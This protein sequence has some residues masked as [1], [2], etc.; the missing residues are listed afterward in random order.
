VTYF[1]KEMILENVISQQAPQ[2]QTPSRAPLQAA[3]VPLISGRRLLQRE[4]A[5]S[6]L[7]LEDKI[8]DTRTSLSPI[9]PTVLM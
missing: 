1:S 5:A 9:L 7:L 6:D 4:N 8:V 2:K 3:V